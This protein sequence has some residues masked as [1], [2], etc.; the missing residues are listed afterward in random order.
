MFSHKRLDVQETTTQQNNKHK[1]TLTPK[2]SKTTNLYCHIKQKHLTEYKE[3]QRSCDESSTAFV[4]SKPNI[5][6]DYCYI[7]NNI[8][9]MIFFLVHTAQSY[10]IQYILKIYFCSE[11]VSTRN[12]GSPF[13][14]PLIILKTS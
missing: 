11:V 6:L 3:S 4:N 5:F 14:T 2:G 9:I 12:F 7:V 10:C 8:I 1:K 13:L